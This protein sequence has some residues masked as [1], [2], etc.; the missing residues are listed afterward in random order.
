VVQLNQF[1]AQTAMFVIYLFCIF[2][3]FLIIY[4]YMRVCGFCLYY[5]Y[6]ILFFSS[7]II[8]Y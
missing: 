4:I 7:F 5:N 2:F 8:L 1:R 6:R 3:I